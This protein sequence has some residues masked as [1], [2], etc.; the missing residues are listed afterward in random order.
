MNIAS[1]HESKLAEIYI[2]ASTLQW[3]VTQKTTRQVWLLMVQIHYKY[4]TAIKSNTQRAPPK[5]RRGQQQ[6]SLPATALGI[7]NRSPITPY[8][9]EVRDPQLQ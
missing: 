6:P 1:N 9:R 3:A 8:I 7:L 2:C 5:E 4:C